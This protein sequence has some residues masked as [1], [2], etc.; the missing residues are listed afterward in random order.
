MVIFGVALVC[1]FRN[2]KCSICG[3]LENPILP[4]TRKPLRLG[5]DASEVD[6]FVGLIHFDTIEALVEIEM[7][8]RAAEF[9]VGGKPEP[10]L[11]LLLD[12]FL[13]LAI[14]DRFQRFSGD[15][16]LGAALRA[17]PSAPPGATGC[18]HDR[19]EKAAVVRCDIVFYSGLVTAGPVPAV[20][21]G[22]AVP[23]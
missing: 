15:L 2:L 16:A 19:R 8:P 9:A 21:L 17:L 23:S 5:V 1:A 18:R 13:D 22:S 20:S 11:L 3:W 6:A 14:F 10:D 4:T 12:D 7:P